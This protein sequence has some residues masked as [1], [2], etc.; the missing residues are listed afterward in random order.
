M[1]PFPDKDFF[2]FGLRG[3]QD[4]IEPMDHAHRH[5]EIELFSTED[6]GFTRKFGE[7]ITSFSKDEIAIFWG[8]IPHQ[9]LKMPKKRRGFIA[10]FPLESVLQWQLPPRF[11]NEILGG[12][13][14]RIQRSKTVEV[15]LS[16]LKQWLPLPKQ[17]TSNL[18]PNSE[19]MII[20]GCLGV[21]AEE[22]L[23]G[24]PIQGRALPAP[25]GKRHVS[26]MIEFT[27]CNR[28]E[29]LVA[30]DICSC[31]DLHPAY[32]RALF[33]KTVGTSLHQFLIKLRLEDA[34][35]MLVNSDALILDVALDCGFGSLSRFHA[36]FKE[37]IG[38]T[39]RAFR[40]Y[41]REAYKMGG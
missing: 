24:L 29:S 41:T 3:R 18:L 36:V 15:A 2:P 10:Y 6:G 9:L 35:N 28:R 20:E 40:Q 4:F 23:E 11:V 33:K 38:M 8:C 7:E 12:R 5:T 31:A 25:E 30:D 32:G 26:K 27:V 1:Q 17:A 21:L 39:P 14:F 22:A 13:C 16:A 37:R 34:K 19:H